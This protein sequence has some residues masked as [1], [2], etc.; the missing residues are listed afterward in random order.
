MCISKD[1]ETKLHVVENEKKEILKQLEALEEKKIEL[2]IYIEEL[3]LVSEESESLANELGISDPRSVNVSTEDVEEKQSSVKE[4]LEMKVREMELEKKIQKQKLKLTINLFKLNEFENQDRG[5]CY[6]R[7]FCRIFHTK[8]NWEKSLS[9]ELLQ[10]LIPTTPIDSC[11]DCG[12]SF[13]D[14][15]SLKKHIG[16]VHKVGVR[17][18]ETESGEVLLI[19]DSVLQGEVLRL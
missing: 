1:I 10:R 11:K 17:R 18:E 8:H 15:N 19:Q 3:K 2:N 6:C 7:G 5:K 13:G 4:I 14:Q 9:K 16:A 12:K